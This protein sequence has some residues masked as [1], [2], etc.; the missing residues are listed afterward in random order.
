M[1]IMMLDVEE[2]LKIIDDLLEDDLTSLEENIIRG[3]WEN[4]QYKE[5]ATDNHREKSYITNVAYELLKKISLALDEKVNR[6]KLKSAIKKYKK[7]C[8]INLPEHQE[9]TFNYKDTKI[10]KNNLFV[11]QGNFYQTDIQ[12]SVKDSEQKD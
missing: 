3:I 7:R 2:A 6:S 10:R 9:V 11:N 1:S 12:E 8:Q 4:K 5:I